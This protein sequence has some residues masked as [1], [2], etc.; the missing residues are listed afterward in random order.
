[1]DGKATPGY[2]PALRWDPAVPWTAFEA[3][4][5]LVTPTSVTSDFKQNIVA[6]C[7]GIHNR[8]VRMLLC[9]SRWGPTCCLYGHSYG[10]GVSCCGDFARN[11]GYRCC[12]SSCCGDDANNDDSSS[13]GSVGVIVGLSV[14]ISVAIGLGVVA[15]RGCV[16]GERKVTV[17]AAG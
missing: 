10:L 9:R 4:P 6:P 5:Y 8:V 14:G 7:T 3:T 16:T 12:A 1:M 2:V 17:A 13:S 15:I 11:P